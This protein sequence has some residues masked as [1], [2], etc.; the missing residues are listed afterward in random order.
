MRKLGIILTAIG[1][2]QFF[3]QIIS[4]I[5]GKG[6]DNELFITSCSFFAIGIILFSSANIVKIKPRENPNII[7][8][9]AGGKFVGVFFI[10]LFSIALFGRI[11]LS[12]TENTFEGQVKNVNQSCPI[13]IANGTGQITSIAIKDSMVVY[14]LTYDAN[15]ITL[16]R[17]KENPDNYKR[18]IILSSYLLNGQN[19]NGDKFMKIILDNHY[20]IAFKVQSNKGEEFTISANTSE[21]KV[22]LQEAEKSPTESMKEVLE[23]QIKDN[24]SILPTRLDD[25]MTLVAILCDSISLIY[26]VVIEE[27]LTIS[28]I[29]DNNTPIDR[30]AIL[31]ELYCEPSSKANLDMCFIGNFNLVYRYVDVMNTDS[32]DIIFTHREISDIVRIPKSLNLR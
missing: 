6:L 17:L 13:P 14:T 10:V 28:D 16:D 24:Q 25:D 11:A 30:S 9:W 23:W 12:I 5:K 27:P 19:K 20:G 29:K 7:K 15:V 22:L 3:V 2:I 4:L 31:R 32:C 21:L 18:V 1:I 8:R 26:R